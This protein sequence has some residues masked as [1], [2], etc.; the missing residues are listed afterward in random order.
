MSIFGNLSDLAHEIRSGVGTVLTI[1]GSKLEADARARVECGPQWLTEFEEQRDSLEPA[2]MCEFH[3]P[4]CAGEA[5]WC[6]HLKDSAA[7][8]AAADPS[9]TVPNA[10]SV[11]GDCPGSDS[12]ILPTV[13]PGPQTSHPPSYQE[14]VSEAH[15]RN[16][17]W[18]WEY[19]ASG[20]S[21][22]LCGYVDRSFP[23]PVVVAGESPRE[24][25]EQPSL[26]EPAEAEDADELAYPFCCY[27]P[28]EVTHEDLAAHLIGAAIRANTGHVDV[29]V[30]AFASSLLADFN[31]TRR[32]AAGE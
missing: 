8:S 29:L 10:H 23:A 4:W 31:I 12:V 28:A 11:V 19:D 13:E 14:A 2:D 7:V 26:G 22:K 3:G 15:P 32:E 9:P 5:S 6:H 24:E 18:L 17:V 30:E 20:R 16:H 25:D 1:L 27:E 21:C